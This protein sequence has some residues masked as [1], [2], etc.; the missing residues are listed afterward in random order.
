MVLPYL[1]PFPPK[2]VGYQ[3]HVFVLFK[4]DKKLSLDEYKID[5]PFDLKKR[6]FNTLEF[7]RK[8]QDEITPAGLAFF[9][10]DYDKSLTDFYHEKL[11]MKEPIYE[12]DWPKPYRRDQTWFPLRK[13][14]NLFMDLHRD[15]KQINKEYLE[16]EL[17]KTHPFDGP[18]PEL[19][20][21]NAHP[22]KDVPSW[23]KTEKMK[24]RLG[25][26]RINDYKYN[27]K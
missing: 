1:Q 21:K 14:F 2:G 17:A 20:Y 7:Y 4:Q 27:R 12:Y 25:W 26:G 22:I 23:Y 18:E 15:P 10:A 16:R 5:Q 8:L 9:Q 3:R 24:D 19:R 11:N 6:N 13:P